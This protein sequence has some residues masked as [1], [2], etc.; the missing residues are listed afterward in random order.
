MYSYLCHETSQTVSVL[1]KIAGLV[2]Y[3]VVELLGIKVAGNTH[4]DIT[5]HFFPKHSEHLKVWREKLD[6]ANFY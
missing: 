2:V 5:I 6:G 3:P 1:R 4:S